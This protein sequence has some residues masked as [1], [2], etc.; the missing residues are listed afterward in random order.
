[1]KILI[2]PDSFKESLSAPQVA[3]NI[4]LGLAQALPNAE[5]A[6]LP[7]ADGGEG[8]VEVLLQAL[9]GNTMHSQVVGPL[10]VQL[11]APWGLFETPQNATAVIEVASASGLDKVPIDKRDPLLTTSYGCGQLIQQ[12]LDMGVRSFIIALGG[13]ACNDGGAGL[14]A[15]LGMRFLNQHGKDIG[16]G[17]AA[18]ANLVSI[19]ASGFDTRLVECHIRLACDVT[20]PLLGEQGAS[21]TFGPQKGATPEQV[22][23]LDSVLTQFADV[24][25]AHTGKQHRHFAGAGAAG[26]IGFAALQY[27]N[28]QMMSGIDLV[29]DTIEFTQ[30]LQGSDWV[31]TGEGRLDDQSQYGKVAWGVAQQAKIAGVPTIAVAGSVDISPDVLASMGILSAFSITPSPCSLSDALNVAPQNLQRTAYNIGMLLHHHTS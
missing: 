10:G 14:L 3:H 1:M 30:H 31:I 29:L 13:S 15:A 24:S 21:H 7:V 28:A 5:I 20:N 19:D 4:A 11:S 18:L 9:A 26:G 27:L 12:A 2:A 17:A 22:L 8:T 23:V 16:Y 25:E 6:C